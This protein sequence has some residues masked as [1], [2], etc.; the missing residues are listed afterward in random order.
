VIVEAPGEEIASVAYRGLTAG[1]FERIDAYAG[2]E[3]GVS[4]RLEVMAALD[5]GD[6]EPVYVYVAGEATQ[7]RYRL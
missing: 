1:D 7:R 3:E 2:V 6:E 5:G 4:S